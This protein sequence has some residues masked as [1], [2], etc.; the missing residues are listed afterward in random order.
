VV[1]VVIALPWGV[2]LIYINPVPTV[3][4]RRKKS[5]CEFHKTMSS[6]A[7]RRFGIKIYNVIYQRAV[8]KQFSGLFSVIPAEAGIH[9]FW[10]T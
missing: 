2:G 1:T 3:V 4:K 7:V 10:T 8:E 5:K 6:G 9:V